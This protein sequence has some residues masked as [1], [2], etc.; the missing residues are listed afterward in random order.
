MV[1]S[2]KSTK[3]LHPNL[4]FCAYYAPLHANFLIYEIN[5]L[6]S[7]VQC[8]LYIHYTVEWVDFL[9]QKCIRWHLIRVMFHQFNQIYFILNFLAYFQRDAG[10]LQ[11][12][13]FKISRE[14]IISK[15]I[16]KFLYIF[17]SKTSHT[18]YS[19]YFPPE[20]VKISLQAKLD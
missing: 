3:S 17:E 6:Y 5:C 15:R 20:K 14:K 9:Y 18:R 13:F 7:I 19:L 4:Y 16:N 11:R 8:T 12:P 10:F 1:K 2:K